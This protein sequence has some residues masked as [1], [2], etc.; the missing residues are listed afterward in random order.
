VL[1]FLC[2][3]MED[4]SVDRVIAC[5]HPVNEDAT[6]FCDTAA[7]S[8]DKS[9]RAMSDGLP[10]STLTGPCCYAVI[11][12]QTVVADD[13][14][15]DPKWVKFQEFAKPLGIRSAWSTPIF[16]NEG[17]VLGTFAHYYFEA[18]DP[19]P[20]DERMMEHAFMHRGG[21][22][23]GRIGGPHGGRARRFGARSAGVRRF[24]PAAREL[25]EARCAAD[26]VVQTPS[27]L[28]VQDGRVPLA[29]RGE[30]ARQ[31]ALVLRVQV[32]R[33]L[34]QRRHDHV[35]RL[36]RCGSVSDLLK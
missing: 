4:E 28:E 29:D 26:A 30:R 14:A 20:R 10:V 13:M 24:V 7:P 11:T 9:Y 17:K 2:R 5:I 22:D 18:R 23:D 31:N 32:R 8:L 6:V 25:Q 36:H 34:C 21:D 35:E 3:T 27:T 15:T 19:S 16:S 1:D 33:L 12:R